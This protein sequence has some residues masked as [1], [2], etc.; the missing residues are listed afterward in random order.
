MAIL[1]I[2]LVH[3]PFA[4]KILL[5]GDLC[6]YNNFFTKSKL[7]IKSLATHPDSSLFEIKQCFVINLLLIPILPR[8][9]SLL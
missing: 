6:S 2:N 4:C 9:V 8:I 3:Y 5:P 1:P 7:Y